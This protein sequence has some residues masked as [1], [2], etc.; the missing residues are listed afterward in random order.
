M[1]ILFAAALAP[2]GAFGAEISE[3][4]APAEAKPA[5]VVAMD[6]QKGRSVRAGE[7]LT[8]G[9]EPALY[10]SRHNQRYELSPRSVAEFDGQGAFRL[11][12]GSAAAESRDETALTT[13]GSKVEYVGRVLVSYDH[14]ERSTSVFVLDGE[15]RLVNAHREDSSLRLERYHGATLV[16]GEVVPHLIRQ[17][18][19]GSV[20]SWLKGYSW[21]E[22]RRAALLKG[23]PGGPVLAEKQA[24]KYLE[25]TKIEDYFSSIETADELHQ[26]DYYEKKFDD[27]DKVV[28]EQNSKSSAGKTLSPEEAALISLPKTQIDLGFDLGPEFLTADQKAREVAHAGARLA[29]ARR[30]PA[31]ALPRAVKAPKREALAAEAGDPDVNTVLE[32]LRQ[33]RSGNSKAAYSQAPARTRAPSSVPEPVVPDPVYDYSQNF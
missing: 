17:L 18:D 14:Q 21:P 27:P 23:M 28:A 10:V 2:A 4:S 29:P 26:P 9:A 24:P 5:A 32:R 22:E 30:A 33:V 8:A 25:D 13:A 11:L 12:R 6:A 7:L 15:A 3:P 31:S 1:L 20:Q 16:V 19:V